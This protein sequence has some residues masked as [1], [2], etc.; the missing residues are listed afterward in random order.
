MPINYVLSPTPLW[1]LIGKTGELSG[2]YMLAFRQDNKSERK[3][4]YRNAAGT[5]EWPEKIVFNASGQQGPFYL[6]DDEPYYIEY[7]DN[8]NN[9]I[10]SIENVTPPGGDGGGTI[11]IS[12]YTDNY[13]KNPSFLFSE[14]DTLTNPSTEEK[15]ANP[16]WFFEKSDTSVEDELS[17]ND[18]PIDAQS[19]ESNPYR[20]LKYITQNV[21]AGTE[22]EKWIYYIFPDVRTFQNT[23]LTFAV[24]MKSS[25]SS[26]VELKYKQDF[27]SGGTPSPTVTQV[28]TTFSTSQSW[29][30]YTFSFTVDSTAGKVRGTNG[31]DIFSVGLALPLNTLCEIDLS[32]FQFEKGDSVPVFED[33]PASE[34]IKDLIPAKPYIQKKVP[35]HF[36]GVDA[37]NQ[38]AFLNAMPAGTKILWPWKYPLIHE[39]LGIYMDEPYWLPINGNTYNKEDYPVLW[40]LA[41]QTPGYTTTDTTFTFP[42]TRGYF[43]RNLGGVDP[44]GIRN[45]GSLQADAFKSHTHIFNGAQAGAVKVSDGSDYFH[46]G[47]GAKETG[48]AGDAETRPY[49]MAEYWLIK[50]Q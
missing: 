5:R 15:L 28:V 36:I 8:E 2:N 35:G 24:W 32:Q 17:F 42:D 46:T 13:I 23:Q 47:I 7:Y 33:V 6:A 18:F 27:G 19:P 26:L 20:Y 39:E 21:S 4:I 45:P 3:I 34:L 30:K 14:F 12:N 44:D 29:A 10:D 1:T 37:N 16:S 25:T 11:N 38:L 40:Y 43:G 48:A 49:N 50:A 22:T 31:D 9:L 41:S